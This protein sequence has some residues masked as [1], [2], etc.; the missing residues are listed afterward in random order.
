MKIYGILLI[1]IVLSLISCN[2][3]KSSNEIEVSKL[4]KSSKIE[5]ESKEVYETAIFLIKDSDFYVDLD[6]VDTEYQKLK[7]KNPELALNFAK[8]LKEYGF[9]LQFK[10]ID[11]EVELDNK[12]RAE[13]NNS[14]AGKIQREH[15][16]WSR[17]D[18]RRLAN[19]EIWIG[20]SLEMLKYL[21][22]EP[23]TSNPSNYGN[24]VEW[25]WCWN[26]YSPSCFYGKADKIVTAYN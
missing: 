3:K 17:S 15:P 11:N 18:C 2:D 4:S 23:D 21:R 10:K 22:G 16:D 24:G 9:D 7:N 12:R 5:E 26:G 19:K 14:K 6:S 8:D 1:F 13:W 25:Q 20:M